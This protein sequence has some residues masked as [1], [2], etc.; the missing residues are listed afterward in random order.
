MLFLYNRKDSL[1]I[2]SSNILQYLSIIFIDHFLILFPHYK[3]LDYKT[4]QSK[5]Q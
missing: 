4:A 2:L 3:G 1:K 5:Q